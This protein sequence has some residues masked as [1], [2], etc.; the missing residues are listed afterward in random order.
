MKT[1]HKGKFN[2]LKIINKGKRIQVFTLEDIAKNK[3]VK[4]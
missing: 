3:K 4:L 1:L 2:E